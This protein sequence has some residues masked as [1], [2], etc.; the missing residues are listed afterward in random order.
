MTG[1]H[2]GATDAERERQALIQRKWTIITCPTCRQETPML[3]VWRGIRSVGA[4]DSL[5]K[6]AESRCAH[7]RTT[8]DADA[9]MRLLPD[10]W[11][12]EYAVPADPLVECQ[13][14]P[15]DGHTLIVVA[16]RLLVLHKKAD[17]GTR[18][19]MGHYGPTDPLQVNE[20]TVPPAESWPWVPSVT[21]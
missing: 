13:G 18:T 11:C 3:I 7:C 20:S 12:D 8:P 10:A 16:R 4:R 5:T 14:G 2:N 1:D 21:E 6:W 9:I 19:I 15:L 17:D